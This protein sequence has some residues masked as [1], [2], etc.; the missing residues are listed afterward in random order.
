LAARRRRAIEDEAFDD[1]PLVHVNRVTRVAGAMQMQN[2]RAVYGMTNVRYTHTPFLPHV[3][4][5]V[6]SARSSMVLW[7]FAPMLQNW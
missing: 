2:E 5:L 3:K 6:G 7:L 4:P 1:R